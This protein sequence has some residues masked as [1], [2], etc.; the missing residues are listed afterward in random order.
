MVSS[1][2]SSPPASATPTTSPTASPAPTTTQSAPKPAS[3]PSQSPSPSR[4]ATRARLPPRAP[5]SHKSPS[6]STGGHHRARPRL[7]APFAACRQRPV[8]R[9]PAVAASRTS[10]AEGATCAAALVAA[11]LIAGCAGAGADSPPASP[12]TL[13]ASPAAKAAVDTHAQSGSAA[14]ARDTPPARYVFVERPATVRHRPTIRS[15]ALGRLTTRTQDGTDELVQLLGRR[16]DWLLVRTPLRTRPQR[17]WIPKSA[18]SAAVR[19]PHA[20]GRRPVPPDRDPPARRPDRPARPRRGRQAV[21]ADP[22]RALLRPRPAHRPAGQGR[23]WARRVRH[24][25]ALAVHHRVARWQ[26]RRDPR[27]QRARADP[28]RVSHGCVRMRN[29]DIRRLSRAMPV[30]TPVVIR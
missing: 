1:S 25:G 30:G 14:A 13:A 16:R 24:L 23:L 9:R 5:Q 2:S 8:T 21:D 3:T 6:P 22:R 19:C 20:T 18:A 11:A 17:G 29:R 28:G 27:H 12:S 10:W 4:A 26:L 15:A 7:R